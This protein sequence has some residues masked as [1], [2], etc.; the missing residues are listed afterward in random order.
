M[1]FAEST[2]ASGA[3]HS[4]HASAG[5]T[6]LLLRAC[7]PVRPSSRRCSRP[8]IYIR[9]GTQ[10]TRNHVT[11]CEI[12]V[13]VAVLVV[14]SRRLDVSEPCGITF[15][16]VLGEQ[17]FVGFRVVDADLPIFQLG[18]SALE[19]SRL[20][21]AV[22]ESAGEDIRHRCCLSDANCYVGY[23]LDAFGVAAWLTETN[24]TTRVPQHS[25]DRLVDIAG[26]ACHAEQH[27]GH[28]QPMAGHR[29]VRE[30]SSHFGTTVCISILSQTLT[31]AGGRGGHPSCAFFWLIRGDLLQKPSRVA[32]AAG[33]MQ[34]EVDRAC[35]ELV[36]KRGSFGKLLV[37][38]SEHEQID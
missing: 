15:G 23:D 16:N 37:G 13:Q 29:V 11:S 7:R 12:R 25:L 9:E 18:A 26:G 32:R 17:L 1:F 34:I 14:E 5:Y 20:V 6:Q 19:E 21:D 36:D 22:G 2:R 8:V 27:A 31:C 24:G 38:D 10:K 30:F 3:A 35:R 4:S 33:D 28:G